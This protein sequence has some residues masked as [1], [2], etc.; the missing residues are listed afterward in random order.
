MRSHP[1]SNWVTPTLLRSR[2][3][4][5]A[6]CR[7]LCLD[8]ANCRTTFCVRLKSCLNCLYF[9][10]ELNDLRLLLADLLFLLLDQ[11]LLFFCR[12]DQQCGEPAVIDALGIRA[13]LLPGNHLRNDGADLLRNHSYFVLTICL[14]I[15]GDATQL[16]DFC[17]RVMQRVDVCLP[18]ARA[19]SCPAITHRLACALGNG[20]NI[21]RG[22]RP[23][24]NIYSPLACASQY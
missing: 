6:K 20:Q 13:V 19:E 2:K 1:C 16:F 18:T 14:Q 12:L 11:R 21:R 22:C 23:D 15:I 3:P 10:S 8:S 5:L 17:Q 4:L 24:A 9:P 7:S